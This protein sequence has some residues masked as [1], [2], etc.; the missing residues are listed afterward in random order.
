MPTRSEVV[1]EQLV[2]LGQ[3]LR[4]LWVA[5]TT[6]PTKQARKDRAWSVL[7]GALTVAATMVA[8]RGTAKV[9]S[10]L[11]GEVPPVG[12]AARPTSSDTSSGQQTDLQQ[13]RPP[14]GVSA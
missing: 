9:W 6:D 3:N 13:A 10:I 1:S 5:A 8:R 7:T 4:D 11:T 14:A 12:T 2:A